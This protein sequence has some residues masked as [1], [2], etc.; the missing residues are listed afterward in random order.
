MLFEHKRVKEGKMDIG[1][2]KHLL[3]EDGKFNLPDDIPLEVIERL[4]SAGHKC[5]EP[6]KLKAEKKAEKLKVEKPVK[7]DP[8]FVKAKAVE[9][10]TAAPPTKAPEVAEKPPVSPTEEVKA[11]QDPLPL[12][13][14]VK[15]IGEKT[16]KRILDKYG[17]LDSIKNCSSD[18]LAA[19]ID[20]LNEVEAK[21][22]V[23]K[24][25]SL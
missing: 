13:T 8:E 6:E 11:P 20:G 7:V 23:E 2:R 3:I 12:L 5:L 9:P 16:A 21:A 25:K 1:R 17:D 19:D 24:L 10:K 4:V 15:G 18:T 14:S 22:L